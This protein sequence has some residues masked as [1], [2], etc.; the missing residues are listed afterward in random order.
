[1][2]NTLSTNWIYPQGW[3]GYLIDGQGFRRV[4]IQC[5]NYSD[6]TDESDAIKLDIS[7]LQTVNGSVPNRTVIEKIQYKTHGMEVDIEWDRAPN[8]LIARLPAGEDGCI[9]WR[10]QGG[11]VDPSDGINDGTGDIIFTTRDA[12]S[13]DTYDI[14]LWVRLKED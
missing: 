9:D 12:D 13:G 3:D 6:G 10:H 5:L 1:M 4:V 7:E 14:T 2:A 8:K 11:N